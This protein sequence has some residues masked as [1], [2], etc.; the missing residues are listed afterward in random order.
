[1]QTPPKK[2]HSPAH[3]VRISDEAV[4]HAPHDG[5]KWAPQSTDPRVTNL[6]CWSRVCPAGTDQSRASAR[7][8]NGI[9]DAS[10]LENWRENAFGIHRQFTDGF[11]SEQF[12]T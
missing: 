12:V 3:V 7:A 5:A 11:L 2:A 10:T 6:T 1:V 4:R 8:R 9:D